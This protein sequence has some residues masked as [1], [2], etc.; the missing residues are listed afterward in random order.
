MHSVCSDIAVTVL[1][2]WCKLV[3]QGTSAPPF[4]LLRSPLLLLFADGGLRYQ[5]FCTLKQSKLHWDLQVNVLHHNVSC[6]SDM[7]I[8]QDIAILLSTVENSI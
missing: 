1:K 4:W 8:A 3:Q 7:L 2:R 6:I 5:G